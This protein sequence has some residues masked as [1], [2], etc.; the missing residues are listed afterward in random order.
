MKRFVP[1]LLF[2]TSVLLWSC[3]DQKKPDM[4]PPPPPPPAVEEAVIST[5]KSQEV[6]NHH[7]ATFGQNDLEALMTDYTENS[8][9]IT[10]DTTYTGLA[11]IK[12]LFG[13]LL[14]LFPTEGTDFKVDQMIVQDDLAYIVW[15]A[16]T[17]TVDIP[18]GTD[19]YL[20]EDGKILRQTFAAAVN[21]KEAVENSEE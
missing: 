14:P 10:P 12:A 2:A 20:I 16:N 18:L 6:L 7:L 1:V 5:K 4:P 17:P 21:P 8:V 19:T 13:N 3:G 15:H 9:V 11:S